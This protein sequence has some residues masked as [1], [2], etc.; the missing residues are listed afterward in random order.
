MNPPT[1]EEKGYRI[2]FP[3]GENKLMKIS[4]ILPMIICRP[5]T[6]SKLYNRFANV[7]PH[8]ESEDERA[9][10]RYYSITTPAK[11]RLRVKM[12]L[13]KIRGVK[14]PNKSRSRMKTKSEDYKEIEGVLINTCVFNY[15]VG[16]NHA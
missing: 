3:T 10:L 5:K 16:V 9:K 13:A 15:P 2:I 14:P 4:E 12:L 7:R 11:D 8:T 1:K 6:R